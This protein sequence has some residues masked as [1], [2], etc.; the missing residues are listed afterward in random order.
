[1]GK[2]TPRLDEKSQI[3]VLGTVQIGCKGARGPWVVK[4]GEK[5]GLNISD[6]LATQKSVYE[7][8]RL[9]AA[10]PH[11]RAELVQCVSPVLA[12]VDRVPR[13]GDLAVRAVGEAQHGGSKRFLDLNFSR[14][15]LQVR[16]FR[17]K[18]GL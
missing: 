7:T 11:P 13:L 15:P 4:V 12:R 5:V 18:I 3:V 9:I 17:R 1:M 14:Q 2:Y 6:V 10:A 8:E 16:R